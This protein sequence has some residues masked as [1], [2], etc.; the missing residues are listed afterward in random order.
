MWRA[1]QLRKWVPGGTSSS[2]STTPCAFFQKPSIGLALSARAEIHD[3]NGQTGS[4]LQRFFFFSFSRKRSRQA[5]SHKLG[6]TEVTPRN[7]ALSLTSVHPAEKSGRR[8]FYREI[9]S[10][11]NT[12]SEFLP[13]CSAL[14]FVL[15][16][17]VPGQKKIRKIFALKKPIMLNSTTS[18]GSVFIMF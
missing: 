14:D 8:K 16:V 10:M 11:S 4:A 7:L 9:C 18:G 2:L 1:S 6:I 15:V 3:G 13:V 17:T 12:A 5:A